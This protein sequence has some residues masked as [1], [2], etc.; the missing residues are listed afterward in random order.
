MNENY[1]VHPKFQDNNLKTENLDE[2]MISNL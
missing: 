1:I 2:I